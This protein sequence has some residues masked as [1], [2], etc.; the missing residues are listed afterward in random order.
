MVKEN[1]MLNLKEMEEIAK[2]ATRDALQ[3]HRKPD[4]D[5]RDLTLGTEI[6]N[7]EGIFELYFAAERPQDA[8]VI[9][10][11]RV[12]RHTGAV[13]VEVFLEKLAD[14]AETQGGKD[15]RSSENSDA[16]AGDSPID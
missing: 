14:H 16:T 2:K 10:C 15:T 12:D 4:D 8:K 1:K 11:A 5:M 9:S 7:E 6:T 13:S 3:G